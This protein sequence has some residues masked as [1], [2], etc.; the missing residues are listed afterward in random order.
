MWSAIVYEKREG[1]ALKLPEHIETIIARMTGAGFA[2]WAVGGCVRDL[3]RGR[4]P[5]DFDLTTSAL[6]EETMAVFAGSSSVHSA[7]IPTGLKH[8]TITLVTPGGPVEITTFRVDGSYSDSRRPDGVTF[9]RSLEEDLARRDFTVNAMAW[10]GRDNPVLCDPFG[11]Q[12]DLAAG[13]IRCVGDPERRFTE[14]ALRILRGVRFAAQLDFAL[15]VATGEALLSLRN[16]LAYVAAERISTELGKLLIGPAA[17]RVLGEFSPVLGEI[18]PEWTGVLPDF[19]RLP[20]DKPLRLALLLVHCRG[21]AEAILRR[22]KV[23]GAL[24]DQVCALCRAFPH[25]LTAERAHLCRRISQLGFACTAGLARL[26]YAAGALDGCGLSDCLSLLEDIR[27]N[28]DCVSLDAFA[29][30]GRDLLSDGFSPG[31]DIGAVR[32]VL[33]DRVLDGKL[34]N[35][36]QVLL[37]EARI[38]L[39][40]DTST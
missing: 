26:Q 24:F 2:C 37:N 35:N 19:A 39:G 12:N 36:R 40:K 30:S 10:G 4:E 20:A 21:N 15:D 32:K 3:L 23:G 22:L 8:G 33:F 31:P 6:P 7:V 38:I 34:P 29:L 9:T 5:G 27:A 17:G 25:T 14:D 16:R 18:L 28:G 11:G 13:I 1:I